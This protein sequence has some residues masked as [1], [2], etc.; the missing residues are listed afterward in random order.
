MRFLSLLR[1]YY[2]LPFPLS[3]PFY[4][5]FSKSI[6]AAGGRQTSERRYRGECISAPSERANKFA[7]AKR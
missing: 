3:V 1:T 2:F 4:H 7:A 5:K 6:I